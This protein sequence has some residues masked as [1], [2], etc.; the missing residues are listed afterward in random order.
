MRRFLL[1]LPCLCV[2]VIRAA[3]EPTA[4]ERLATC[5]TGTFSSADQARGDQN[6]HDVTLHVIAIWSDRSDGPWLYV[7][8]ALPDA[9]DHPFRQCI[10][11]LAARPDGAVQFRV[12]DLPDPIAA[13]NAW[14]DP[15]R[16]AKLTP[17]DLTAHEGGSVVLRLQPDGSFKGG[18]EGKGTASSLRGASYATT[19]LTVTA[20][21]TV[22]WER[23]YNAS[24]VQVWGSLHGG[25]V[26]RRVE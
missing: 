5:L 9:P 15:A 10:Y 21:E 3:A 4:L 13:T 14:K 2:L 18:T 20:K 25:Y 23:A 12:L 26:F 7:E 16:L 6:F 11:Q 17:A 1:I 24:D 19:E 22:I 8:Q